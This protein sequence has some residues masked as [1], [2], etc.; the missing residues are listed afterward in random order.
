MV[1][2]L[3]VWRLLRK[4]KLDA[5]TEI[6]ERFF[7]AQTSNVDDRYVTKEDFFG[8]FCYSN[9]DFPMEKA[10]RSATLEFLASHIDLFQ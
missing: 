4:G 7:L 9:V 1:I 2:Q 3:L 8:R 6:C 10:P 5:K